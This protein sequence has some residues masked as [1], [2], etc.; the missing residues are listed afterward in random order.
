ML[1]T[2]RIRSLLPCVLLLAGCSHPAVLRVDDP[3]PARSPDSVEIL[4]DAPD[5]PYRTV[6]L[7]QSTRRNLFRDVEELKAQVREKAAEVGA[8]AVILSLS[9]DPGTEE[10]TG[11]TTGGEVVFVGSGGGDTK[12]VGRAIVFT[13]S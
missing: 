4:L 6:A 9:Q 3:A 13:D 11:V 7:I 8:D 2:P 10:R 5:R 12:V 1:D